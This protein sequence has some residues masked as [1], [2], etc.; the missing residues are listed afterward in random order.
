M[1][2]TLFLHQQL[3]LSAVQEHDKEEAPKG[4]WRLVAGGTL[5]FNG[6]KGKLEIYNQI[7]RSV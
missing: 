2:Q 5:P 7:Q 3:S 4:M 1:Q 6:G